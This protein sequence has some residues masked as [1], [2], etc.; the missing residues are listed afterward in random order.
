MSKRQDSAQEFRDILDRANAM[1]KAGEARVEMQNALQS[2]FQLEWDE[3]FLSA[4]PAWVQETRDP[5]AFNAIQSMVDVLAV[6]EPTVTIEIPRD[7]VNDIE[8]QPDQIN[9]NAPG[10]MPD[11]LT[12]QT[13]QM[14][15]MG[16][17]GMS[18][19]MMGDPSMMGGGDGMQSPAMMG[20]MMGG[21]A[22][23]PMMH[24]P[25]GGTMPGGGDSEDPLGMMTPQGEG[26]MTPDKLAEILEGVVRLAHRQNDSRREFSFQRDLLYSLFISG[27]AAVKVADLRLTNL[28]KDDK[29]NSLYGKSP[30]VI[31][32]LPPQNVYYE[33]D[34]L[35]LAAVLQREVRT[36]REMRA[37]YKA[38]LDDSSFKGSGDERVVYAEWW[39]RE[40][41]CKWIERSIKIDTKIT[42]GVDN[43]LL[44]ES[45]RENSL[46]FI[47]YVVR[48][49]RGTSL[50]EKNQ[51]LPSLYAGYKSKMF[52]RSNL[53]L[54]VISS[55]AFAMANPQWL[56]KNG[57]GE[58]PL[59]IDF[60]GPQTYPLAQ[61]ESIERLEVALPGDLYQVFQLISGKVEESTVSKI[62]MGQ[63]N[64]GAHIAASAINLM[65][66]GGKLTIFPIQQA[67]QETY[68]AIAQMIF[69]YVKVYDQ[70]APDEATEEADT[71]A[72]TEGAPTLAKTV[73]KN[74]LQLVLASKAQTIVP[75][76]IPDYLDISYE[77]KADLP[78]DKIAI[79]NSALQ[80]L[81][82]LISKETAWDWIGL[83]DKAKEQERLDQDQA[84]VLAQQAN[85]AGQQP[86]V[87]PE[88]YT[89]SI[90][91]KDLTPDEKAQFG[92]QIGIQTQQDTVPPQPGM[93]AGQGDL[94]GA[95]GSQDGLPSSTLPPNVAQGMPVDWNPQADQQGIGD[96]ANQMMQGGQPQ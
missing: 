15:M 73:K 43:E 92:K 39:T 87:P 40:R 28:W 42:G 35:G 62:L 93:D 10:A 4:K 27:Q 12:M 64:F 57:T 53:F 70:F 46:G 79:L 69:D 33:F 65:V 82:K 23:P 5:T 80:A 85:A 75:D 91:W 3:K 31:K 84:E 52:Y 41:T 30:F 63:G 88:K 50:F 11:A 86:S 38:K 17:P 7:A 76:M 96:L 47:P 18:D 22:L 72:E 90:A 95:P 51:V 44:L 34:E 48:T 20:G 16:A 24:P 67:A 32:P 49:G 74:G 66:Q 83:E 77:L 13:D 1:V 37:K 36:L 26:A 81:G 54:T 55:L 60:S 58:K 21:G 68:A 71:G 29:R 14:P 9:E 2:I 6:N 89:I 19:P 94:S 78:Q 56:H 25:T 61:D 45:P 8:N 59:V